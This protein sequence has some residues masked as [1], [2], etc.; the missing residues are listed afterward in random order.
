M[1]NAC[2]ER[3]EKVW[4]KTEIIKVKFTGDEIMLVFAT[5][6]AA[7]RCAVG[8]NREMRELLKPYGLSAGTGVHCGQLVE[9][10]IGSEEIKAYD[11]I[12]D[13]VNTA[14]RICDAAAGGE[15]LISESV[16]AEI[17]DHATVSETRKLSVKGKAEPLIVY[18][19]ED[20]RE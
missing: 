6:D 15:V 2:F 10:L 12:G 14:K 19:L 8:I 4:S 11:I 16:Y 9:G 5:A 20:M 3:A 17:A 13:A 18:A 7:A 1:L